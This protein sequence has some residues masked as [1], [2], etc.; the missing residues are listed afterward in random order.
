MI[1]FQRTLRNRIKLTGVGVHSGRKVNMELHPADKDAGIVF[2]R[3]DKDPSVKIE[4]HARNVSST[5]LNTS[6]SKNGIEIGTVEHLLSAISGVGID[7][8]VI[9]IDG[10]ELPIMDGSTAPFVFLLQSAG[11]MEQAGAVKKFIKILKTIEVRVE[12]KYVSLSPYHGFRVSVE[13]DYKHPVFTESTSAYTLDF[14]RSNYDK[15]SRARTFGFLAD[16]EMI[17]QNN[18]ALGASLLNAVILD[19]YKVVNENG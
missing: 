4:A 11:I 10:P 8:L 19:E 18:L 12:D 15:I 14:S 9:E 13:L 2:I 17:R 6:L 1:S 16:Y 3:T 7:N 5:S